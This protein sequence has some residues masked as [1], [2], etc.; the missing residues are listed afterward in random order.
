MDEP[1]S[2]E[3]MR[4]CLEDLARVNRWFLGYRP[5]LDW[6]GGID[7]GHRD[8]PLRILDVGCGYGDGLRRIEGWAQYRGIA[9][10][11][12]GIDLN[13]DSIA[14]ASEASGT[15]SRIRWHTADVFNYQVQRPAHVVISSLFTHHLADV[16]VVR[17]VRWMEKNAVLGWFVND[18]SRAPV[19]YHLFRWFSK[20]AG[21]HPFVQHDGPVSFLRAF[22]AEDWK[23]LS[24]C[25]GLS[26]GEVDILAYK[27]ARL[28]V[29][30]RKPR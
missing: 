15:E 10:E 11:L 5:V 4:A 25:A 13:P 6:L 23:R 3:V 19:P 24:S 8:E 22:V 12:T 27:P 20:V 30:R 7:G 17:F 26:H 28:C 16:D 29:S 1:C 18:L 21:L 9:V 2:R 14:I